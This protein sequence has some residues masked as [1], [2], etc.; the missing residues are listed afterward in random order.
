MMM[1][2]TVSQALDRRLFHYSMVSLISPS[3]GGS[4]MMWSSSSSPSLTKMWCW[5]KFHYTGLQFSW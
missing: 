5:C 2:T 1:M 4:M 3:K